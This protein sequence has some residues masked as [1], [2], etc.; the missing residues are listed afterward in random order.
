MLHNELFW[1]GVIR[2]DFVEEIRTFGQA[3]KDRILKAFGNIEQEAEKLEKEEYK[4][5][6]QSPGAYFD[7]SE[8][9]EMA[10]D[11]AIDFYVN[12]KSL[13]QGIVNMFAVGIYGLFTQQLML[14][15]R[16][17]LLEIHEE[18]DQKL[19][20]M[21]VIRSRLREDGI[22]IESFRSYRKIREL[23][24]VVNTVKH[25]EGWAAKE[26]RKIRPDLFI[27]PGSTLFKPLF[28]ED[29]FVRPEDIVDRQVKLTRLRH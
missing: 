8:A 19:F 16:K 9:A 13:E 21:D 14:L 6:L 22:D 12:M 17:E 4:R 18:N 20:E 2:R 29:F 10:K 23:K 1:A 7:G 27:S 26:L 28:G 25:A 3:L 24:L 15:H 11:R 5:L